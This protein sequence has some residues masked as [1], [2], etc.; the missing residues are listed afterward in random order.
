MREAGIRTAF[1]RTGLV[2]AREGGA[3]AKLFPLYKAGLGG[4]F[5][6]GR[7][8]W[9][10]I[11]LHDEVAAIRHLIDTEGLSGPFNLTAPNP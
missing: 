7:Q 3:W 10:F 8:Y 11:A 9:S 6:N 4:H 1:A 5:G 2:V